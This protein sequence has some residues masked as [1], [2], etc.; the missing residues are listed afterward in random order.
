M[1]AAEFRNLLELG[2]AAGVR[3]FA[4][5][6]FPGA[7]QPESRE[8]AEIAMHYARTQA[9]SVTFRSRAYSHAWLSERRIPSALPDALRPSAERLYPVYADAVGIAV[10]TENPLLK[11]VVAH[12]REAMEYAVED[13]FADGRKDTPFVR[14]RMQEA[15]ARTYKKL[16]GVSI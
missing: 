4:A 16:L 1:S 6:A 8:Q 15:R 14:T 13:A 3:A 5:R 9:E 12:V 2:D 10:T 11:P 7:P